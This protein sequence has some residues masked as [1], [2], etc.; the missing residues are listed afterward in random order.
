VNFDNSHYILDGEYK[1]FI[2]NNVSHFRR[3]FAGVYE[4]E[5]GESEGLCW[6]F[7]DTKDTGRHGGGMDVGG[8]DERM[9]QWLWYVIC[10]AVYVLLL[11]N[12]FYTRGKGRD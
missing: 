10:Y 11:L 9:A 6:R 7:G 3:E 4:N 5:V 2:E 12:Y 8:V 1:V